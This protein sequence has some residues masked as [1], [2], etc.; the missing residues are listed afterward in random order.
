[1]LQGSSLLKE[2]NSFSQEKP[3]RFMPW[4]GVWFQR[5]VCDISGEVFHLI[6]IWTKQD[7]FTTCLSG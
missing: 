7:G 3:P 6:W 4:F 5:T 2:Y 1:M